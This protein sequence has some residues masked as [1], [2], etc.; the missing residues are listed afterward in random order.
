MAYFPLAHGKLA[1]NPKLAA[2]CAKYGKTQSQVA[3]GWP[4]R[5]AAVFTTPRASNPKHVLEDVAA[6]GWNISDQDAK[7]PGLLFS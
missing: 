6:S 5:R 2:V 4:A 1:S 7:E 3:L